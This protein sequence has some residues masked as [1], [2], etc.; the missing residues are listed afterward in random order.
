MSKLRGSSKELDAHLDDLESFSRAISKHC[1]NRMHLTRVFGPGE[2]ELERQRNNLNR[3]IVRNKL[4]EGKLEDILLN[5]MIPRSNKLHY[6]LVCKVYE[7][8]LSDPELVTRFQ[9]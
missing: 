9:S 1:K 7:W 3:R 2:T 5:K 6:L 4:A 8:R